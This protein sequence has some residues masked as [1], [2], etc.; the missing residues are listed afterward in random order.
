[1]TELYQSCDLPLCRT[2]VEMER[3]GVLVDRAALEASCL[4]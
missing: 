4:S 2:L 3:E 1:M